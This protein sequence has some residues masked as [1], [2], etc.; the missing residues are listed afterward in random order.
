MHRAERLP[1]TTVQHEMLLSADRA[2]PTVDFLIRVNRILLAFSGA[3]AIETI[4]RE[5]SRFSRW[6]MQKTPERFCRLDDLPLHLMVPR[7][8][9]RQSC[10]RDPEHAWKI[11]LGTDAPSALL[12]IDGAQHLKGYA[13]FQTRVG[14]DLNGFV[15]YKSRAP[16]SRKVQEV[17]R[18]ASQTLAFAI[19]FQ[20]I[21]LA[22]RERVKE[23]TCLYHIGRATSDANADI[24]KILRRIAESL[25]P[26]WQYPEITRARI[27]I[28]EKV[29]ETHLLGATRHVQRSD[30]IV[31]GIH[32]GWVEVEYAEERPDLDE[33]P[34]L[35]EERRLLDL[36]A[37]DIALIV[38][39]KRAD[40]ERSK[41]EEQV[42]RADRLAT[43]GQ[44]AAGVTHELNEPLG[45]ILGFTQLAKKTPAL[46]AQ[47]QQDLTKIESAALYA[48]EV[49]RKLMLFARQKPPSKKLLSVN[50]IVLD[51][52][53]LLEARGAKQGIRFD[54]RLGQDLPQITAD[55]SQITQVIVNLIVN[56]IQAMPESGT[57]IIDT[58]QE[59][60]EIAL[61][62]SDTGVGIGQEDIDKI[63]DPFFTTKSASEGT[64]LGLAVVHGIVTAHRGRIEVNSQVGAGS[65]FRVVLPAGGS[66]S[67]T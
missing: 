29:F 26:A 39:Q 1:L 56:A 50:E 14:D 47:L 16:F 23:L 24:D 15:M 35:S 3:E 41:L 17:L 42:R 57:V 58:V 19:A 33:G 63:F 9:V 65:R 6:E 53:A 36:V 49:V 66:E 11:H 8:N 54:C 21:R 13:L 10:F 62:V 40:A 55:P 38:E 12:G 28:D 34:F 18:T 51:S 44:L 25:P 32:R 43:I 30:I 37:N 2:E 22:Q 4:I 31:G 48:R 60:D 52:M 67:E 20:R 5:S 46:S 61:T 7:P 59:G 64:G 45:S 27:R